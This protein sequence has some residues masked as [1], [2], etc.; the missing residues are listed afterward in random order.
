MVLCVILCLLEKEIAVPSLGGIFFFDPELLGL[1]IRT[2]DGFLILGGL[3]CTA[4]SWGYF[5]PRRFTKYRTVR[6]GP[7]PCPL[8]PVRW[9]CCLPAFPADRPGVPQRA[10]RRPIRPAA[11]GCLGTHHAASFLM[12]R[13]K[14]PPPPLQASVKRLP[15]FA[16]TFDPSQ[17]LKERPETSFGGRCLEPKPE[18]E[19]SQRC[20]WGV[21]EEVRLCGSSCT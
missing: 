5:F 4:C 19:E 10:G 1:L 15:P 13:R 3:F 21:K 8:G 20:G 14:I 6:C 11:H 9:H 16:P 12:H 17:S 2:S 18:R 7:T